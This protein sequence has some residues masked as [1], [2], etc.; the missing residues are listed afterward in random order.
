MTAPTTI[1]LRAETKPLEARSA[2]KHF[3]LI[4]LLRSL[5]ANLKANIVTPGN[6]KELIA[7]GYDVR[8]ERSKQRIF[9]DEEFEAVGVTLVE[10][11]SWPKAPRSHL[12][13]GLKEIPE[14][15]AFPLEH[16]HIQFAHC[17][18]YQSGW[19]DVLSRF[20]RGGGTLYDLEYLLHP[21]TGARVAAFGR[22]AGYCGAA[23]ALKKHL[24]G[25]HLFHSITPY[26]SASDL[27]A[28]IHLS[29]M[30]AASFPR[31]F[32]MGA[33]GRCG[34]GAVQFLHDLSIPDEYITQ[35]DIAETSAGPGPYREIVLDN[36]IF[37]NCIFVPPSANAAVSPFLTLPFLIENAEKRRLSTICD[38]S[39]DYNNPQNPIPVYAQ[40]TTF[41]KPTVQVEGV[42]GLD[43]ISIDHLPSL[44]PRES[45][46]EYGKDLLPWLLK[47]DVRESEEV[48]RGAERAFREKLKELEGKEGD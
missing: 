41:E 12:I 13:L 32:V 7:H 14:E 37:I 9:S 46:E 23:L 40:A 35:W 15:P 3:P 38:V 11:G 48:W 18:K 26:P 1:H 20:A 21:T 25:N 31:I 27:I 5:S 16:T 2:R 24:L 10:E 43:V 39:C 28:D 34:R 17:Y 44:L 6:A 45:S 22:S 8:V 29:L 30:Q 4:D 33:K 19:K 42:E 47:L 36:D